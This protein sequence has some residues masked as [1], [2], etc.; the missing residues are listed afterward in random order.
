MVFRFPH[1][2]PLRGF[3]DPITRFVAVSPLLSHR[4]GYLPR[5]CVGRPEHN[6]SCYPQTQPEQEITHP[7]LE[8]KLCIFFVAE[9]S[10]AV[11]SP[12]SIHGKHPARRERGRPR[13]VNVGPVDYA[14]YRG[15]AGQ[16]AW[17]MHR[18]TGLGVLLFVYLHIIDT[19]MIGW[20]PH[21]YN[22]AMALYRMTVFRIGEIILVGAVLY[23][24]LN[25]M[26]IIVMDFWPRTTVVQKQLLYGVWVAF[27]GLYVP[28][29][30][31]MVHWM[32]TGKP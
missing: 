16:W 6:R 32:V 9:A 21:A 3:S 15:R 25:G 11:N 13:R 5:T 2:S 29:I 22:E 20:G 28:A 1:C 4:K 23:H 30:Y 10:I 26:R 14:R 7:E 12:A 17:I 24:A 27:V 19:S 18:L 31:F 8:G